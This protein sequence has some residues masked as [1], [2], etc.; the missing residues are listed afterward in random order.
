MRQDLYRYYRMLPWRAADFGGKFVSIYQTFDPF[1][2]ATFREKTDGGIAYDTGTECIPSIRLE[3]LY[4]GMTD[5][6]YLRLLEE[7]AKRRRGEALAAEALRFA[8]QSL[9]DVPARYPH[10]ASKADEFRDKCIDYLLKLG[11]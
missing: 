8:A 3:N 2:A 5:V 7:T 1:P 10:D 9:R 6:R 11:K 4:R